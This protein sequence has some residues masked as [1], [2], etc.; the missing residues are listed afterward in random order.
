M[1]HRPF[2]RFCADIED[3]QVR[4]ADVVCFLREVWEKLE[5]KVIDAGWGFTKM[6]LTSLRKM[7]VKTMIE[8]QIK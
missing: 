3:E 7:T 6:S 4:I 1:C 5:T 2:Q 8:G